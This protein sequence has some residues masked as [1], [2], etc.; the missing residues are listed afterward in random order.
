[1]FRKKKSKRGIIDESLT[2]ISE[3]GARRQVIYA[4]LT[5]ILSVVLVI[6]FR[7]KTNHLLETI[8]IIGFVSSSILAGMK[9]ANRMDK[10]K[11]KCRE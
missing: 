11:R 6:I 9:L 7:P 2:P 8:A 5:F 10:K 4:S 3:A 1:M